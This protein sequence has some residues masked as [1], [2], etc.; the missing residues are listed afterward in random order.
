MAHPTLKSLSPGERL[1]I[2]RLR[3]NKRQPEAAL[4]L[5]VS[6]G[7]YALWEK[8]QGDI[9]AVQLLTELTDA[10]RCLLHRRRAGWTQMEAAKAAGVC[11]WWVNL[12]EHGKAPAAKLL[13]YWEAR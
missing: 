7:R 13:A 3:G 11:R 4:S 10:E 9:P 12:I 2:H 8:D 1:L 6:V 5:G